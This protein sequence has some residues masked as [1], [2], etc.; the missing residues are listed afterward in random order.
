[1]IRPLMHMRGRKG[2][3]GQRGDEGRNDACRRDTPAYESI[4]AHR[5]PASSSLTSTVLQLKC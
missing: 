5:I 1:M 3:Q 2:Q 4:D